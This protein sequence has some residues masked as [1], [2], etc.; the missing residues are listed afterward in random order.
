MPLRRTWT[1][2]FNLKGALCGLLVCCLS[3]GCFTPLAAQRWSG[4]DRV[5]ALGLRLGDGAT[6]RWILVGGEKRREGRFSPGVAGGDCDALT[7]RVNTE[8]GVATLTDDAW[9]WASLRTGPG[10]VALLDHEAGPCDAG[11][12]VASVRTEDDP[13][14]GV[15]LGGQTA[16]RAEVK[17]PRRRGMGPALPLAAIGDA[18]LVLSGLALVGAVAALTFFDEGPVWYTWTKTHG[19]ERHR[20]PEDETI[21]HAPDRGVYP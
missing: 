15:R 19:S 5:S 9:T 17:P 1:G 6:I 13:I 7:V 16:Y 8:D 3:F 10:E 12:I 4:R 20:L 2:S 18:I 14:V 21:G 11:L